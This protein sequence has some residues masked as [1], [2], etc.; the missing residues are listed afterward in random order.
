MSRAF[1][2]EPEPGA[3]G[4]P[5]AERPISEHVNYVTPN[6]LAQLKDELDRLGRRRIE[7]LETLEGAGGSLPPD[8]EQMLREELAYVDR[9]M[10][11]FDRRLESAVPVDPADQPR[12]E[13]AF[14][15][16]VTVAAPGSRVADEPGASVSLDSRP[17]QVWTIVGEDESD[18]DAG[19]VSYV[20]PLAVALLGAKVGQMVSWRR[21][22]G[23]L[24]LKVEH[25]SYLRSTAG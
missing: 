5:P 22:A 6:G 24:R 21:P 10:R 2:K 9:D 20:S 12:H 23:T 1:V 3:A 16:T 13:V 15:A 25:I 17:V 19:K 4:D 11:Y 14:G 18:P 7:L 8:R